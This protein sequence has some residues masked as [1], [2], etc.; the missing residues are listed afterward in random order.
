[1]ARLHRI[2]F[3]AIIQGAPAPPPA[4]ALGRRRVIRADQDRPDR[5]FGWIWL[6]RW[7]RGRLGR[8]LGRDWRRNPSGHDAPSR[9]RQA[10]PI[11]S[12]SADAASNAVAGSGAMSGI[13]SG[14]ICGSMTRGRAGGSAAVA[15]SCPFEH[16]ED[17]EAL[18][19]ERVG[20]GRADIGRQV[21]LFGTRSGHLGQAISS[22][23]RRRGPRRP[24]RRLPRG[25]SPAGACSTCSGTPSTC[26]RSGISPGALSTAAI[27]VSEER[28]PCPPRREPARRRFPRN[29]PPFQPRPPRPTRSPA[30]GRRAAGGGGACGDARPPPRSRPHRLA[31]P[32]GRPWLAPRSR[33]RLPPPPRHRPHR[34]GPRRT[35]ARRLPRP[36]RPRGAPRRGCRRRA[37]RAR[38]RS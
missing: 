4:L 20:R 17:V 30:A 38:A 3:Q 26:D 13:G 12:G 37:A 2:R 11:P 9:S 33:S 28:R 10:P 35:Q 8:R 5:R 22:V 18:S 32:P 36:P 16:V 14:A 31:R 29:H 6:L 15:A 1:M 23:R 7:C 19:T 27:S 21:R 25:S 34:R 24:R